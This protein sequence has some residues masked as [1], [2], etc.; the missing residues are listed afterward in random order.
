MIINR[1]LLLTL[2]L[3]L[4]NN[5]SHAMFHSATRINSA[6]KI[7]PA[8]TLSAYLQRLSSAC[9]PQQIT[10]SSG[11]RY[12]VAGVA[13]A[14]SVLYGTHLVQANVEQRKAAG[15]EKKAKAL[16]EKE[17]RQLPSLHA[18]DR[19]SYANF[20]KAVIASDKDPH[21]FITKDE[22]MPEP[23]HIEHGKRHLV[24]KAMAGKTPLRMACEFNDSELLNLL[25]K[26]GGRS[27][28]NDSFFIPEYDCYTRNATGSRE[29]TLLSYAVNNGLKDIIIALLENPNITIDLEKT[30]RLIN[31]PRYSPGVDT[32]EA[33][34]K[35]RKEQAV[36]AEK[37][38]LMQKFNI[39]TP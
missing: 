6:T 28:I 38:R 25:I 7:N 19:V 30:D 32:Y 18:Q 10:A 34:R 17:K 37:Q 26:H 13:T 14:G 21:E 31:H 3:L 23:H 24:T 5:Q 1:P 39:Q 22:P 2:S 20:I 11:G 16:A 35:P 36:N 9:I 8:Q 27:L 4:I 12:F 29:N 33:Y 15:R